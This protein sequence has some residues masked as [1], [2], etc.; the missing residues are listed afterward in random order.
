M[1]I[2][3]VVTYV[4]QD[5]AFGGPVAVALAQ[6]DEL[7]RRGHEVDLL[8][9]WDGQAVLPASDVTQRLFSVRRIGPGFGGLIAPGLISWMRRHGREYDVVHVHLARDLITLSAARIA[10]TQG[11]RL[12][13]QPHGMIMPDRRPKSRAMDALA[14][15]GVLRKASAVFTLTEQDNAG[16][17]DVVGDALPTR[18]MIPNGITRPSI[19]VSNERGNPPVV[20]F[21]ARL[22]PRKRVLAFAEAA[23]MLIDRGVKAQFEVFGPDEGDLARLDAYIAK[24]G[25]ADRVVYRGT[26]PQGKACEQ[27]RRASVYVLPAV[28]E[29]F[30]MTVL[31]A[32]SVGTPVVLGE[33]CGIAAELKKLGAV[34]VSDGSPSDLAEKIT[35][36]MPGG[37]DRLERIACG[38]DSIDNWFSIGA[39]ADRLALAYEAAPSRRATSLTEKPFRPVPSRRR[40]P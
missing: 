21:L 9:G 19:P 13:V 23:H 7:V 1:K 12:V 39:V 3:H 10:L 15:R 11:R 34:N 8:A 22:H 36:L 30:P 24:H 18:R 14:T 33:D 26:V 27:L 40:S 4:S 6:T 5:G 29:V 31:E 20:M 17:A 38:I 37:P 2:A 32:L 35:R 25:L 28:R 16:I